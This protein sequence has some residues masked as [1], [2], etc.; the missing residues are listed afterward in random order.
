MEQSKFKKLAL[1]GIT[2][3]VILA[4]QSPVDLNASTNV[5]STLA[6]GCGKHCG[7][8]KSQIAEG[9]CGSKP[10]PQQQYR[11]YA[12]ETSAGCGGARPSRGN[13]PENITA[14]CSRPQSPQQQYPSYTAENATFDAQ[15][16]TASCSARQQPQG[17]RPRNYTADA[18]DSMQMQSSKQMTES[19]LMNQLSPEMRTSFQNLSPEGKAMALR[20][21]NQY[22]DKNQAVKEAARKMMD[23]R[24]ST[25][26][27]GRGY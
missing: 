24:S 2:G 12:P 16:Q 6:A 18:T 26:Q 15:Q 25:G 10:N 19:D 8:A 1:M 4:S 7:G 5:G 23:K 14:S 11:T 9:G 27:G 22:Q 3:G 20:L 17:Q 21:A 13:S